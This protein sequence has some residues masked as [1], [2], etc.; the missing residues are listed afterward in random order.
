MALFS[1][2]VVFTWGRF[3]TSKKS[4]PNV[5]LTVLPFS[6][7]IFTCGFNIGSLNVFFPQVR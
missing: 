7:V 6:I 2:G 5:T 1:I 3:F 4:T